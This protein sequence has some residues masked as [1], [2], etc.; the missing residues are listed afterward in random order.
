MDKVRHQSMLWF[1]LHDHCLQNAN[2][3]AFMAQFQCKSISPILAF[4]VLHVQIILKYLNWA[5]QCIWHIRI[6]LVRHF[7]GPRCALRDK[8]TRTGP[9]YQIYKP[10]T[11]ACSKT[12][13]INRELDSQTERRRILNSHHRNRIHRKGLPIQVH[14]FYCCGPHLGLEYPEIP[15][16]GYVWPT[17]NGI[18][19]SLWWFYYCNNKNCTT[20]LFHLFT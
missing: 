8:W 1:C 20:H 19:L 12:E 7:T 17:S 18:I 10:V 11:M 15:Q 9:L 2:F 13:I 6:G 16:Q 14:G 4:F 5:T 3:L